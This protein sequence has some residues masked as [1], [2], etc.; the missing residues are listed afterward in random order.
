MNKKRKYTY[1][2][3]TSTVLAIVL[4][5]IA[6]LII[7]SLSDKV[8]LTVD[9]TEG[10]ILKFS[11]ETNEVLDSLE[12][13]VDIISLI[14]QSDVSSDALQLEE[15]M[16][17][18]ATASDKI[19]YRRIDASKNPG[20]LSH[21]EVNGKPLKDAYNIIIETERMYSVI[22]VDDI[23]ERIKYNNM[24]YYQSATLSAEQHFSS[25]IV[26]VTKGSNINT[27]VL[28]GHGELYGAQFFSETLLPGSGYNFETLSLLTDEIPD[29]ADM[30]AIV[31]PKNDYSVEEIAKLD[32]FM[33]KGG[34]VQ[35]FLGAQTPN[36]PNLFA[37][38]DEWGIEVGEGVVADD[39]ASRYTESRTVLMPVI[40]E[41]DVTKELIFENMNV[42]F[43]ASRPLFA[44]DRIDVYTSPVATTGD[45]GYVKRN[46]ISVYDIFEEGDKRGKSNVALMSEKVIDKETVARMYVSGSVS[47]LESDLNK[48]F[49]SN[50][51]SYMN[52]QTSLYIM[53]K[54]VIQQHLAI[55]QSTVYL[56]SL[57]VIIVIPVIIMAAGFIIWIKRRHL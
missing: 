21:Y 46:I 4:I 38:L 5:I 13:N 19:E 53:P 50:L 56:Y 30:I 2:A 52:G 24:D 45:E 31:S 29:G 9:L 40:P 25:A 32:S 10:Q 11:D 41:N 1:A 6:N 34:K 17:R 55:N 15:V 33:T 36:L 18:Y 57:L 7:V 42:V 16:K 44:T 3:I 26:K 48:T 47:F 43:P 51:V 14:P 49:Y 35:V 54:L 8:N 23:F 39:D 37:Y 28:S 20:I 22:S 12:M 27:Y